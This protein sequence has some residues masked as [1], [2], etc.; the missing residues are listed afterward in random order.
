MVTSFFTLEPP[1]Q[2]RVPALKPKPQPNTQAPLAP[3]RTQRTRT[4][5]RHWTCVVPPTPAFFFAGAKAVTIMRFKPP[6]LANAGVVT[7]QGGSGTMAAMTISSR[8]APRGS[9]TKVVTVEI[10][11]PG[12][13]DTNSSFNMSFDVDTDALEEVM[14]AY[15]GQT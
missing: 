11:A 15:D 14:K 6:L 3:A 1:P 12:S 9:A 4:V 13:E 7:N 2:I 5:L 8:P 10:A